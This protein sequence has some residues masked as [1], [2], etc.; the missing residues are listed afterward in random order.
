MVSGRLL[1]DLQEM[2]I[3]LKE[4]PYEKKGYWFDGELEKN[5]LLPAVEAFDHYGYFIEDIVCVDHVENLELIYHFNHWEDPKRFSLRLRVNPEDPE[6][7][8]ISSIYPGGGWHEREIHE[9]FG[10]SFK[11]HPNLSFLFLHPEIEYY[12]L[13]KT[14]VKIPEEKRKILQGKSLELEEEAFWINMGP[15]HPS[16]HGVLRLLLKMR[17]EFIEEI[18]PVLGYMHRMQEKM[19]EVRTYQQYYPNTARLDYVGP[20]AFSMCYCGALERLCEIEVPERAEMIRLITLE[21]NRIASHLLWLGTYLLDLGAATP[22]FFA[23]QDREAILDILEGLTGSRLTYCYYRIGGVYED[24]N[25]SF[26]KK[27]EDF[28]RLMRS[29]L[30]IYDDLVTGNAIFMART[31]GIGVIDKE[32]AR[33]FGLTGPNL[34]ASGVPYDVRLSEPYAGYKFLQPKIALYEEGSCYERYLVRIKEIENS[35][36]LLEEALKRLPDG[37]FRTEKKIKKPPVGDVYFATESPRGQVGIYIVSDG[38]EKPYRLKWRSPSF[39][40]FISF[41]KIGKGMLI[42]DA[43]ATLGSLDLV[44]PEMDR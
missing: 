42:A 23:F 36:D 21:L 31:K 2:G 30:K 43:V 26:L 5:K 38:S 44:V 27:V 15:Q 10:V 19:A 8:S 18:E 25:D 28:I 7:P 41:T 14:P 11:G 29:N 35:L 17:G 34:R 20:L 3:E 9:F 16:T 40:N 39:C 13:R 1:K 24:L 37:P 32:I 33:R 22:Y 6:V 12:P 4:V